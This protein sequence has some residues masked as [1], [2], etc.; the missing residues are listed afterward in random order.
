[1]LTAYLL[2]I[3]SA[4]AVTLAVTPIVARVAF[5][6]GAVDR[7]R[8]GR[9]HSLPMP[10][11]GGVAV[12]LGFHASC[13]LVFQLPLAGHVRILDFSLW[14][15]LASS[16]CALLFVGLLDDVYNLSPIRKLLGQ[17]LVAS[18]MFL[19]G[20]R[21]GALFGGAWPVWIDYPL[22]LAY[23]LFLLNAFNLIDGLDGLAAGVA[24][25]AAAGVTGSLIARGLDLESLI[26]LAF[27]GACLGFLRFNFSPARIFLGDSGSMLLG[28]VL[29]S[30]IL[31][32]AREGS[33]LSATAIPLMA[34]AVPILDTLLA[35]WRRSI[36]VALAYLM[37]QKRPRGIMGRDLEHIHHRFL[38]AGATHRDC[39]LRIYLANA[40][41]VFFCM[42]CLR[43]GDAGGLLF[44]AGIVSGLCLFISRIAYIELQGTGL[45]MVY[46]LG[47]QTKPG[48]AR[49]CHVSFCF[50]GLA[51]S[52]AAATYV[53]QLGESPT[54]VP[55]AIFFSLTI[56]CALPAWF[57]IWR[58]SPEGPIKV[59]P[60][61][62]LAFCILGITAINFWFVTIYGDFEIQ[63]AIVQSLIYVGLACPIMQALTLAPQ[64]VENCMLY[65]EARPREASRDNV[66]VCGSQSDCR[67]Y[68]LAAAEPG[69]DS[70]QSPCVVGMVNGDPSDVA[71]GGAEEPAVLGAIGDI[72]KILSAHTV[73][74]IV[75]T[76]QLNLEAREEI[77]RI[78]LAHSVPVVE[79]KRSGE[80]SSAGASPEISAE[81]V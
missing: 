43:F 22:T 81:N 8:E 3:C 15:V 61:S 67:Q 48:L 70:V 1:M 56:C 13:L 23:Y 21:F 64:L 46:L 80:A 39:V 30:M 19:A 25:I 9:I 37:N 49:L 16:S 6:I 18:F 60:L 55:E 62:K 17:G 53:A 11:A 59:A 79:W 47:R 78:G 34:M 20:I 36:R 10:K 72:P 28:F 50:L 74:M 38:E 14:L 26:I 68:V 32:T 45:V 12:F 42:L 54:L 5:A 40:V 33:F 77:L 35:V 44:A 27:M 52:L 41:L 4:L 73:D 71:G 69:G 29:A 57:L 76:S 2:A 24:G 51:T 75:L 66:L 63:A 65:G 58:H 7:P 31:L